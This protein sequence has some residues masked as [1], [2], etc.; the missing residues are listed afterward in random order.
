MFLV[1]HSLFITSPMQTRLQ[2]V[3][4]SRYFASEEPI[5]PSMHERRN[6]TEKMHILHLSA[7]LFLT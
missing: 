1:I 5:L 4:G 7:F 2:M 6:K 3:L